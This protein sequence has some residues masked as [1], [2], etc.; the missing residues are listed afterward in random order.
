MLRLNED[1]LRDYYLKKKISGKELPIWGN[2]NHYGQDKFHTKLL[3][4]VK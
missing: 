3:P 2:Y 1:L 4:Y